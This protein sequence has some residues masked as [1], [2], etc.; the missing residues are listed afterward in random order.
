MKRPLLLKVQS[1]LRMAFPL[2]FHLESFQEPDPLS[3][4]VWPVLVDRVVYL[5]GLL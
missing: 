1:L 2:A 3:L 5:L 4:S